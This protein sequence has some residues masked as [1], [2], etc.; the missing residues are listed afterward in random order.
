MYLYMDI[1]DHA[2]AFLLKK[3]DIEAICAL[4]PIGGKSLLE[5]LKSTAGD[6]GLP[7]KILEDDRVVNEAEVHIS[8]GD[9]WCCLEGSPTFI[10]GG[11]M[12]NPRVKV[13]KDG[14]KDTS[15]LSAKEISGGTTVV[16]KPG[17][18][19]WIPAGQPH[20]HSCSDTARLMIIKIP[21]K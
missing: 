2:L 7:F 13:R 15:E 16:L 4:V 1:N 11:I 8:Q 21:V 10:Y 17:D 19:L 12:V 3:E 20:Q 5:P 9:L 14:T 18:W 6:R